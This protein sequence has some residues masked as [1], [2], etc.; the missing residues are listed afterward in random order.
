[1]QKTTQKKDAKKMGKKDAKKDEKKDA[2]KDAKKFYNLGLLH[3]WVAVP[4]QKFLTSSL[5]I[6]LV[7]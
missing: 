4:F 5:F 2:K 1:M 3:W 7:Q 6:Y